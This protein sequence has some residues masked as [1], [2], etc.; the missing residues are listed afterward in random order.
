MKTT[1]VCISKQQ[2]GLLIQASETHE[3]LLEDANW[4]QI[5]ALI[6]FNVCLIL[7]E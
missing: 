3:L 4:S 1:L 2:I 6:I 7:N 5:G